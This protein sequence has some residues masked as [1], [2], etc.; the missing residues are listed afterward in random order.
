MN[1]RRAN[2]SGRVI[3]Q[4]AG[5]PEAADHF[6]RTI[7]NPIRL[8]AILRFLDDRDADELAARYPTGWTRVWGVTPGVS[9]V[10][11]GKWLQFAEGDQ[12]LFC[13]QGKVFAS[14]CLRYR[15]RNRQ[16]ALNLWG[17]DKDGATW[18]YA[19][20]VGEPRDQNI[21]YGQL[22]AVLGYAPDFV[23]LGMNILDDDKSAAMLD[24]FDLADD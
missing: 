8:S 17:S 12:V 22:A 20:F 15:L 16:L 10:N 6:A 2:S 9:G 19:Y 18:E 21:S 7:R 24:A 11:R 3:L 5:G 1:P 23:V 4:P 13:G 14:A